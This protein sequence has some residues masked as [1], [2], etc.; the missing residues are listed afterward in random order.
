MS[1]ETEFPWPICGVCQAA[2]T[3]TAY[4]T[5][6]IGK[7]GEP[8]PVCVKCEMFLSIPVGTPRCFD[9]IAAPRKLVVEAIG[10]YL[11][12]VQRAQERL[13]AFGELHES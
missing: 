2:K 3:I 6:L 8:V 10:D 5:I 1:T 13:S 12:T 7:Q 4:R 11:K 9:E